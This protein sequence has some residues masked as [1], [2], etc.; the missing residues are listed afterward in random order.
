MQTGPQAYGQHAHASSASQLMTTT[1]FLR[2]APLPWT[3]AGG[4]AFGVAGGVLTHVLKNYRDGTTAGVGMMVEEAKE[5]T[6][7]GRGKAV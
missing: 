2:R 3:I 5:L 7:D 6:R 4:A 1:V